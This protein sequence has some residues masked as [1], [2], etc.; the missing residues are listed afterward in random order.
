MDQ[1]VLDAM[2]RW[3]NVP[4]VYGWLSLDC[5]GNYAIKGERIGN[6]AVQ[7]FIAR[8]YASDA[9][10]RWYFQNGPQRVFVRLDCAPFVLRCIPVGDG[11]ALVTHIET[12]VH[13]PRSA[14]LDDTG[15]LLVAFDDTVGVIDDRDLSRVIGGMRN[16][17]GA[18]PG[19]DELQSLCEGR[20]ASAGWHLRTGAAELPLQRICAADIARRFGFDADPR[21]APGEPEC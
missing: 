4:V 14:L 2:A 5:R 16:P 3:P 20:A 11:H 6:P 19:D 17:A 18:P 13:T 10:G 7:A 8:N 15:R 1:A 12:P 21:P 9:Q